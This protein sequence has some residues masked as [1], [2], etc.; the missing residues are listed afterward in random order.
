MTMSFEITQDDVLN[1]LNS[2]NVKLPFNME[3][4]MSIIDDENVSQAALSV[5]IG[6]EEDDEE[7]IDKQTEAAYD[8]IAWQLFQSNFINKKQIE[9][10][11][12]TLLLSRIE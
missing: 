6:D 8:E 10:Y 3:E 11:G 5:D 1:V 12:N 7:V 9:K 4:I 2:Y